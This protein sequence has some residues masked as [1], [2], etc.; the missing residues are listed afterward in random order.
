[1]EQ[2]SF[3]NKIVNFFNKTFRLVVINDETL[4]EEGFLKLSRS[5]IIIL[6]SVLLV[7]AFVISFC[8]IVYSPLNKHLPG[9]SSELVQKELLTLVLKS[10]SLASALSIS[11]LYLS[12]I[13][14]IIKGGS[15]NF[16]Y[17]DDSLNKIDNSE[18]NFFKSKEDSLLRIRVERED[19][20]SINLNSQRKSK[21][22]LF[23]PPIEGFISDSFNLKTNHYGIDL[24]AKTGAKIKSIGE[25]TVVVSDW[26]PQTGYVLG[27]QHSENFISFYK[28]CSVLLKNV[29]DIITTG[30]NIAI[31]GNSGELSSGPH[32]HF[33]LWRRG[34]PLDPSLYISF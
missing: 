20:S 24:V 33:E 14:S 13:E 32:L 22:F 27:I 30:E 11:S 25:G 29:G 8:I 18:I 9:K 21:Q 5:N 31:I 34:V 4:E 7:S 23:F 16:E 15:I 2:K 10:D 26:N 6:A 3:K 1:M 17:L 28:H 19:Q 12:N